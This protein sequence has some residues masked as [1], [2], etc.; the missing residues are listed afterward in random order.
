MAPV[1]PTPTDYTD[2]SPE[3]KMYAPS[4]FKEIRVGYSPRKKF[5]GEEALDT[6]S[7]RIMDMIY[8]NPKKGQTLSRKRHTTDS[9]QPPPPAPAPMQSPTRPAAPQVSADKED[10]ISQDS[11]ENWAGWQ[12]HPGRDQLGRGRDTCR[13][14]L[15]GNRRR[16]GLLLLEEDIWKFRI[17]WAGRRRL[18][19]SGTGC[20]GRG[21]SGQRRKRSYSTV[22]EHFVSGIRLLEILRCTGPD[23]GLMHEYFPGRARCELKSKYNREERT[24][25]NK[26]KQAMGS[27]MLLDDSL[28]N[29]V[30]RLQKEID[31]EAEEKAK[32]KMKKPKG[33]EAGIPF[34]TEYCRTLEEEGPFGTG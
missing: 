29:R 20:G 28:M 2:Y 24:N 26:L 30:E 18:S 32:E 17:G 27:P 13:V 21:H 22:R 15:L 14:K 3:R 9:S 31:E 7:M 16:C 25:W 1:S 4:L 6:K 8:W 33:G 34:S 19:H 10:T 5:N 23:F 11:G 12:Y